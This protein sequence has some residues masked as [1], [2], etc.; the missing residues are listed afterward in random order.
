MPRDASSTQIEIRFPTPRR[1]RLKNGLLEGDRSIRLPRIGWRRPFSRQ[2]AF[3]IFSLPGEAAAAGSD[4]DSQGSL[5][6]F[7]S[8][9]S[10]QLSYTRPR[11][12]P[13]SAAFHRFSHDRRQRDRETEREISWP[14]ESRVFPPIPEI[15]RLEIT[16]PFDG[17]Q[18]E[19][20]GSINLIN[21]AALLIVTSQ[22]HDRYWNL[23]FNFSWR[24]L[25]RNSPCIIS[26]IFSEKY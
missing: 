4:L 26:W 20:L 14:E 6:R 23:V 18:V 8:L 3:V 11:D 15:N 13:F 21:L 17:R 25:Q 10:P 12:P 5:F 2:L 7:S 24:D 22:S 19:I 1:I 16:F 9:I